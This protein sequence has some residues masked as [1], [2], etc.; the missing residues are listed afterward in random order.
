[1]GDVVLSLVLQDRGLFPE[2]R[3]LLEALSAPAASLRP[4]AFVLSN[5]TP[6]AEAQVRPLVASLRDRG[7]H[8]R[9]SGKATKNIGKLLQDASACFARY[10]VI[11]ESG[12]EATVKNL[13]TQ[14]QEKMALAHVAQAVARR[15]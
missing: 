2:G 10:A 6:E 8:A 1:M 12:T 3:P 14:S 7:L 11:L 9:V 13:D 4:D 15:A 5:A